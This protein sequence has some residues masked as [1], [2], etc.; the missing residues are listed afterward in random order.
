MIKSFLN[1]YNLPVWVAY[2][3]LSFPLFYFAYKFCL[4]DFGGEDFFSYYHLY[5]NWDFSKV[6]C[7]FNMR[8]VSAF[9]IYIMNAMG[10]HYDTKIVFTYFH[11]DLDQQVF[12]N[13]IC[14]NYLC[15][16]GT[17]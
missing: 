15:V 17:C 3:L 5:K 16:M 4:P 12:F 2:I 1:S 14:F 13:A 10:L 6:D 7:P 11:P 8:L 9:F